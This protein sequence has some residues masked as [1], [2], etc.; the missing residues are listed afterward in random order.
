M[1]LQYRIVLLGLLKAQKCEFVLLFVAE[2]TNI[3]N[4][5]LE[6]ISRLKKT[7]VLIFYRFLHFV[8]SC[9]LLSFSL[10]I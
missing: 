5:N 3:I 7:H 9:F 6:L 8:S 10:F 1:V 2:Y 4:V